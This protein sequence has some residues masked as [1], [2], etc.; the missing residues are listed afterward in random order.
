[1]AVTPLTGLAEFTEVTTRDRAAVVCFCATWA[2]LCR[3][4]TPVFERLAESPEFAD[5]VGFYRVDI[6]EQ[7]D[8]VRETGTR[9]VP[10]F[11]VFRKGIKLD[12]SVAPDPEALRALVENA[13]KSGSS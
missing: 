13:S 6:D 11:M 1:M 8:I 7:R 4:I 10:V 5:T 2:A 3:S 12:E 9:P